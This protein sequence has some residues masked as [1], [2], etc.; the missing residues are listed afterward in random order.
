MTLVTSWHVIIIKTQ[1][2]KRHRVSS[3]DTFFWESSLFS[4][5]PPSFHLITKMPPRFSFLNSLLLIRHL[6]QNALL[7][8]CGFFS[9]LFYKFLESLMNKFPQRCC[10]TFTLCL[11]PNKWLYLWHVSWG[12]I[13]RREE[14]CNGGAIYRLTHTGSTRFHQYDFPAGE[15]TATRGAVT[16]RKNQLESKVPNINC[17]C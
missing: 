17:A 3:T 2:N 8:F 1:K 7:E 16:V 10:R 5:S 13:G 12:E 14:A 4:I 6:I 15:P 11:S 9:K